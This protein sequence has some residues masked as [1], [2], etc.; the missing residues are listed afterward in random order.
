MVSKPGGSSALWWVKAAADGARAEVPVSVCAI[1]HD[2]VDTRRPNG[3][4]RRRNVLAR[5]EGA[6]RAPGPRRRLFVSKHV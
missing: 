6:G 3:F 4:A 5:D 1:L 2:D